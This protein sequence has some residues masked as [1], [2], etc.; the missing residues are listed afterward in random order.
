[1]DFSVLAEWI[2]EHESVLWWVGSISIAAF[3]GSMLAVPVILIRLPSD[4]FLSN[5]HGGR[6]KKNRPFWYRLIKNIIGGVFV[7]AGL[8]M[9]FLPGQG[10]L[11]LAIGLLLLDFPQKRRILNGIVRRPSILKTINRLRKKAGRPPLKVDPVSE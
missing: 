5:P 10:L 8:L 6:V 2:Q 3:L 7:L 11:T 9:L 4:T 1:V